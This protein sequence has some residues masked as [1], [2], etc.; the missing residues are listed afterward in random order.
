MKW[1]ALIILTLGV[2]FVQIP[3][4]PKKQETKVVDMDYDHYRTTI[5]GLVSIL[6]ACFSSGFAGVYFERIIKSKASNLWLGV[7][8]LGFSF[9]GMLMN[10]GSQI[11]KL[12][13]FHGYNSTTWLAAGG[14]IV[15]LVM[16]YADNILKSFAAALSIII[17][18]IVSAILWDFRPSLLFLIGTFFVLFSIYLYGI[19]EKK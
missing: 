12:G 18:M 15:A 6:L 5:I 10:D 7:F 3:S 1:F 2:A 14:L 8:S 13:F 9:A 19:P 11:S 17:S 16:K 4:S